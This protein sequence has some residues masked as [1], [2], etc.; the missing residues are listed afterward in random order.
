MMA[1]GRILLTG[2]TGF[3]GGELLRRLLARDGRDVVCPVRAASAAAARERGTAALF[4]VL[5]RRP[6]AVEQR[7]VRWV[8]ADLERP[9]LGLADACRADLAH[10][11]DE[12]FH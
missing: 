11:L 10:D 9:G 1:T 3:V 6:S 7:R 2:A 8:P 12:I 5:G 4:A